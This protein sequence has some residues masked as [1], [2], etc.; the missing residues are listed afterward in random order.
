[1]AKFS[2]SGGGGRR[3]VYDFEESAMI[4]PWLLTG[5]RLCFLAS[6]CHTLFVLKARQ[7]RPSPFDSVSI[8]CGFLLLT[9]WLWSRGKAVQAC[10]I[11]NF[12]EVLVFLSWATVLIYLIV[13][14]TYRLSLMGAFTSPL[15]LAMLT[16]ALFFRESS[17]TLV[18]HN[19]YVEFHAALSLIAYGAFGLACVSSIMYLVQERHLKRHHTSS[20]FFNLP[21]INHLSTASLR[22]LWLGFWMLTIAFL[23]GFLSRKPIAD[24]K[25]WASLCIWILYGFLL[26]ANVVR[27]LAAHK[28]AAMS[29]LFF[30]TAL[31]S[32]PGIYYLSSTI[33]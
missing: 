10:P 30:L 33:R 1:M 3:S 15:V 26:I 4:D 2:R 31:M 20:L 8:G 32:L 14:P 11:T 24:L 19:A 18:N 17:P 27:P 29:I 12:H 23:F 9:L 7:F 6:F 5:A 21:P 22:L 16:G 13:G 28:M 25:F